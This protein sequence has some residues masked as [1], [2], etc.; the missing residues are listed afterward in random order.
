[1]LKLSDLP[2]GYT[3]FIESVGG[4]EDFRRRL[5][6][7]GITPGTKVS[8]IRLAPLGDPIQIGIRGYELT[9]RKSEAEKILVSDKSPLQTQ[10]NAND[11][12]IC[13]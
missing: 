5:I 3:G 12:Q 13:R 1:M 9:I 4:K 11:G 6:D 7:M 10:G 2:P 8:V